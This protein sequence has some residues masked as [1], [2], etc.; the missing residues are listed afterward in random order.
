MTLTVDTPEIPPEAPEHPP[1]VGVALSGRDHYSEAYRAAQ[2][3]RLTLRPWQEYALRVITAVDEH[4]KWQ[5][6]EVALVAA[7][8]NGKTKILLPRV[9]MGLARGERMLHAA[10]V[11]EISREVLMQLSPILPKGYKL[12]QANGQESITSPNGR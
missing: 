5:Y 4:D 3:L 12:R 1:R 7:R 2:S 9:M 11:R 6:P 10:Q 8:Q